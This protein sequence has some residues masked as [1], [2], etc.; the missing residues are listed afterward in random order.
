VELFGISGTEFL[1]LVV[2]AVLVTGPKGVVQLFRLFRQGLDLFRSWSA[3]I[4][5]DTNL[6]GLAKEL[7]LDPEKLDLRQYDPRSLV[8]QAVKE[9]MD[10]WAKHAALGSQTPPAP[11]PE[12]EEG[13]AP[14]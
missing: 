13:S 9:E 7:N 2:V 8:R 4:R 5:G 11:A 6:A 14:L 10:A 3:K 1:V 12:I